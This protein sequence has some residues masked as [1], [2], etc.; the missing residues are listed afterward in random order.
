MA[1]NYEFGGIK[2]L[3]IRVSVYNN[4]GI[5]KVCKRSG[6]NDTCHVR[7][8]Q[9]KKVLDH[10]GLFPPSKQNYSSPDQ[11]AEK[12]GHHSTVLCIRTDTHG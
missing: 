11:N 10:Y 7:A 12:L 6:D 2:A 1:N 3:H 5:G 8:C 9:M 4:H